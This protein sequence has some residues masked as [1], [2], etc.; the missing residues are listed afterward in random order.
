MATTEHLA[1]RGG[2]P[3]VPACAH[4]PWPDVREDDRLAVRRAPIAASSPRPP[5]LFDESLILGSE[6]SPLVVQERSLMERYVEASEKT[7]AQLDEVVAAPFE[8]VP[9]A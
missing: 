4:G 5:G 8:P 9:L 1:I 6:G 2:A 7:L 3:T